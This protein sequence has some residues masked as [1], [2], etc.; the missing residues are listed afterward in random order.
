MRK[1]M[2]PDSVMR[3]LADRGGESLFSGGDPDPAAIVRFFRSTVPPEASD[4]L[5][6]ENLAWLS[7]LADCIGAMDERIYEHCRALIDLFRAEIFRAP[8]ERLLSDPA[9]LGVAEKGLRLGILPGD[10]YGKDL[11][12]PHIGFPVL[13]YGGKEERA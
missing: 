3:F 8:R 6:P 9:G 5:S 1:N 4:P 11:P 7:V 2:F 13:M 12:V 10:L